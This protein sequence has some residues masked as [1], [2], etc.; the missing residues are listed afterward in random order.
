MKASRVFSFVLIGLVALWA[1][2]AVA[3]PFT[4][5]SNPDAAYLA[6]TNYIDFSGYT[7]FADYTSITDGFLTVTFGSSMNMRYAPGGG[8][9]TWSCVPDSQRPCD[10]TTLPVLYS[11]G[12]ALIH[13]TLSTPEYI[14]GFEAEPNPFAPYNMTASFFDASHTLLGTITRNVDGT[15][16]AR[17]F[18]ASMDPIM[19]VD[20]SSDVDF[21]V[22]AFRYGDGVPEPS[23][24]ALML[25]GLAGLAILRRRLVS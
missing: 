8:W 7:L 11:N 15:A 6:G 24:Y 9:S 20:F 10:S 21:A 25:T 13:M 12:A 1:S 4:P 19:F 23:T 18:A 5:I 16:G 14:F 2:P 17:L 3:G 22:G